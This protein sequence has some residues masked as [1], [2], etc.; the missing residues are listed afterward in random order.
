MRIK[1][2][3]FKVLSDEESFDIAPITIFTGKN[4]SGKSSANKALLLLK[5]GRIKTEN[6][7]DGLITLDSANILNLGAFE[8]IISHNKDIFSISLPITINHFGKDIFR[9]QLTYRPLNGRAVIQTA[10]V[11]MSDGTVL[12]QYKR[13][14]SEVINDLSEHTKTKPKR[15][16]SKYL[17]GLKDENKDTNY[18]NI[19]ELVQ[20]FWKENKIKFSFLRFLYENKENKTC[21]DLFKIMTEGKKSIAEYFNDDRFKQKSFAAYVESKNKSTREIVNAF[22]KENKNY[23]SSTPIIE[24]VIPRD[25]PEELEMLLHSTDSLIRKYKFTTKTAQKAVKHILNNISIK[26]VSN[27][28]IASLCSENRLSLIDDLIFDAIDNFYLTLQT[29]KIVKREIIEFFEKYFDYRIEYRPN[30][31]KEINKNEFVPFDL[32]FRGSLF[33][34]KVI[35]LFMGEFCQAVNRLTDYLESIIYIPSV[36]TDMNRIIYKNKNA[37][38]LEDFINETFYGED[39]HSINKTLNSIFIIKHLKVFEIGD[40]IEC[41]LIG[42]NIGY[43]IIIHKDNKSL[44]LRDLGYGYSQLLPLI[45]CLGF[46]H[47]TNKRLI[48]IEEP[49][50]HLHPNL[51]SKI[52]DLFVDAIQSNNIRLIIETHSEYLI[53]KLQNLVAAKTINKDD[54]NLYYF[55]SEKKSNKKIIRKL[56][57]ND[58][59]LLI[60]KFGSGFLDEAAKLLQDFYKIN[61]N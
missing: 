5:N 36:K 50:L 17:D 48:I 11:K 61:L 1:I 46:G 32:F 42:S 54:I 19:A 43:E 52:A 37:G 38:Y 33:Y 24:N 4:N 51:Q 26:I 15:Y 29:P 35:S 55:D 53:R 10:N 9:L 56:G 30:I 14:K 58:N 2:S 20:Q 47:K 34:T 45:L 49:E 12:Y 7:I 22:F 27:S 40:S 3:G 28:K 31:N 39:I 59:G 18:F 21:E 25:K 23:N 57:L 41:R 13:R 6:G 44:N 60:D 8:T 16:S